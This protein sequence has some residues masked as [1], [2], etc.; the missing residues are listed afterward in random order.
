M[1]AIGSSKSSQESLKLAF[2]YL[3]KAKALDDSYSV[4]SSTLGWIYVLRGEYD[5]AIAEAERAVA[6]EPNAGTAHIW[7]SLVFTFTGNHDEALP[8]AERALRLDPFPP[9]WWFRALGGAY[10]WVGRYEEA[11]AAHK[12]ALQRAPK[13]ERPVSR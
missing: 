5:N 3:A 2:E 1:T 11:I 10:A 7:M 13:Q 6:L 9:G 8:H 4:A 12:K